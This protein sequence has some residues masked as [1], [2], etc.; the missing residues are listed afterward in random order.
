MSYVRL[1]A[2]REGVKNRCELRG[3]IMREQWTNDAA[4]RM[5][6]DCTVC[7]NSA[8]IDLSTSVIGGEASLKDCLSH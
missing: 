1:Y 4:T 2:R 3:H 7:Y 5:G 6:L 8:I